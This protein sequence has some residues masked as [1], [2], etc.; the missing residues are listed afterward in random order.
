VPA[1]ANIVEGRQLAG[2]RARHARHRHALPYAAIV[3]RGGYEEAG[4]RGRYRLREGDVLLHD[5]FDAHCDRFEAGTCEILNLHL[6][7]DYLP[8]SPFARVRDLDGVVRRARRDAREAAAHLLGH[9]EPVDARARDWPDELAAALW[10]Q[11]RLSLGAW[12]RAHRLSRESVSRTFG[13]IWAVTPA[14]FRADVRARK[15]WRAIV[16]T[17]APLAALAADVGFADQAHLTREVIQ[18]TGRSPGAWRRSNP[19]KT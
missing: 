2:H 11:P 12:A 6:P 10:M 1:F 19:F 4:E 14:R 3:L 8:P 18:L 15:A 16:S 13:R 9:L 5:A 7:F 17:A